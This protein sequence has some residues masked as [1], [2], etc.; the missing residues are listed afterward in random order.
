MPIGGLGDWS[1]DHDSSCVDCLPDVVPVDATSYLFDQDW[2]KFL[3]SEGSVHT[4]EI[5]FSHEYFLSVNIDMDWYARYETKQ[6]VLFSSSY[7]E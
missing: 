2:R 5:D 7:A 3:G 1:G 6:L 4:Q